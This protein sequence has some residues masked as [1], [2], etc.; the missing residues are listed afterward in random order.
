MEI[1]TISDLLDARAKSYADT[2]AVRHRGEARTYREVHADVLR[3]TQVLADRGIQP[4]D[5][6]AIVLPNSLDALV[7]FLAVLRLGAVAVIVNDR[8][9][10]RQVGH[11]VGHSG[12]QV[13][14]THRRLRALLQD[15]QAAGAAVL[16]MTR[17]PAHGTS[18]TGTAAGVRPIIGRDLAA[19][20]YTSGSTGT[21]KGVMVTHTNLL[22]GARIV[23]TYLGLTP[24]DR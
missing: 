8:L 11:I 21:P 5:R 9:T 24:Q 1:F 7:A 18:G 12:A 19:L 3:F 22:A 4:G 6:L 16:D 2:V 15:P 23:A 17:S 20:I 13:V 10:S 14:I